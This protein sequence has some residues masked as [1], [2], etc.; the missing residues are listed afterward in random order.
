MRDNYYNLPIHRCPA[1]LSGCQKLF[2]L[3]ADSWAWLFSWVSLVNILVIPS[4][5]DELSAATPMS[6]LV[7]TTRLTAFSPGLISETNAPNPV[8]LILPG[9]GHSLADLDDRRQLAVGDHLCFH[10]LEDNDGPKELVVTDSGQI[11]VPY[12][13]RVPVQGLTSRQLALAIKTEL[14]AKYYHHATVI[15]AVNAMSRDL[16][17]IYISGALRNSGRMEIPGNEVFTLS[18]A[19]LCA[20]GFTDVA[21]KHHIKLTRH[22]EAGATNELF[23]VDV[24]QILEKGKTEL[25]LPVK[26][27]DMIFVPERMNI[28]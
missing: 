16:G 20:G 19:I 7:I 28:F 12:L 1:R 13:G 22:S 8:G 4:Q 17:M 26:P 25:D 24:G 15:I 21:D 9:G 23:T 5:A 2:G 3:R 18:K 11:E 27:G 6:N 14:E 10:I